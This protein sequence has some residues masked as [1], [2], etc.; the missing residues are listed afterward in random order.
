MSNITGLLNC[1]IKL[2][3][4]QV[5]FLFSYNFY[6]KSNKNSHYCEFTY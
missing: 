3:I 1:I 5:F 2:R 6:T 4:F